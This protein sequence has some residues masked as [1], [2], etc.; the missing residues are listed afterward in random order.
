VTLVVAS[1]N[2]TIV[3]ATTDMLQIMKPKAICGFLGL[4]LGT[5]IAFAAALPD[6]PFV[7]VVGKADIETPPDMAACSLTLRAASKI[8]LGQHRSLRIA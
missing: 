8:P 1:D 4:L 5:S 7:F 2:A 6:Y 3:R